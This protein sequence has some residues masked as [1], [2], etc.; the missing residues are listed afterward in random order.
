MNWKHQLSSD[1]RNKLKNS[2]KDYAS[3]SIMCDNAIIALEQLKSFDK[4]NNYG[5]YEAIEENIDHFQFCK[6]FANGTIP[7]YEWEDYD[8][9]GDLVGMFNSYLNEFYDICDTPIGNNTK[10]CFVGL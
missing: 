6:D 4:V 5:L 10:F 1:F 2:D 9:D 3:I 7:I 8:F